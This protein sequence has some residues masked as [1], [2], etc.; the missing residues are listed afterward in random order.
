MAAPA[1]IDAY[2]RLQF[3]MIHGTHDLLVTMHN[4]GVESI[5]VSPCRV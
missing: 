5:D 3:N 2:N 1:K 4:H